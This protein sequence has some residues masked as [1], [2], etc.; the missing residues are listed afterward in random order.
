MYLFTYLETKIYSNVN[1]KLP[2]PSSYVY[3]QNYFGHLTE[4]FWTDQNMLDTI[5]NILHTI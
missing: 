1:K 4:F 5:Q 2:C 3:V